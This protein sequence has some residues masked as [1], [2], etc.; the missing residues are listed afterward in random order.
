M[1]ELLPSPG[2]ASKPPVEA[3]LVGRVFKTMSE[4]HV[5][6]V[7][8]FRLYAGELR[9]GDEVWN[10]EHETPEKLNHLSVQQGKERIE[11]ERL[12]P[13]TSAPS[14][15]SRTPTPATPSAGGT[16]P[17]RLPPIPF[18]DA[19][20]HVGGAGQAAGR[21]G[22]ARGRAAQ[23]AR[24]RPHLP[25]RVQ[26]RAGPDADPRHGRA[27]LRDHPQ[28]AGAEVRRA[29]GAGAPARRLPRDDQGEG[30]GPGQAQEADR[31]PRPVRRLLDPDRRPCR[32][33]RATSSWTRSWAASSRTSTSRPWIAGSRSRRSAGVVAGYPLV[34]FQVECFDGSYH[35]VDSN[36]MSFK[37][38]GILAFRNVAPEG[39]AGAARAAGGGRAPG[40]R[41]T[42][43][44]T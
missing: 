27:A 4:P 35:D 28:A 39:A 38:A 17:V 21:G 31:R 16:H 33:G 25:L 41:T 8:L 30:R 3:P 14:P 40:R 23:A 9:N 34:D 13:A 44:A 26:L 10:A 43:W 11:V 22:Q 36:E 15:S 5:G 29:R 37:M 32:G 20:G 24:G 7:T 1:V 2:G 42:C 6:D 12:A 19:G 18:P